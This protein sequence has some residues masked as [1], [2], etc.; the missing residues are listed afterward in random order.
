[1]LFA[2]SALVVALWAADLVYGYTHRMK[3]CPPV[4]Y[5]RQNGKLVVA[6]KAD[7]IPKE[8]YPPCRAEAW[9]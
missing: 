5:A 3:D 1:M 9:P 6:N 2:L 7:F 8:G 4:K